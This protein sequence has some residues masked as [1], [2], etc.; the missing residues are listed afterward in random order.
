M[1][2]RPRLAVSVAPT[3]PPG[4]GG[5]KRPQPTGGPREEGPRRRAMKKTGVSPRRRFASRWPVVL[6]L[7]LGVVAS[8]LA[9]V[10]HPSTGLAA[11]E[12]GTWVAMNAAPLSARLGH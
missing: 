3:D 7:A 1:R 8:S 11:G 2:D 9:P 5:R 6:F 12:A 4:R 10:V